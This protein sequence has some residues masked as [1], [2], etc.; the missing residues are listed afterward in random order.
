M[1]SISGRALGRTR[2]PPHLRVDQIPILAR[3]AGL[4]QTLSAK[5]PYHEALPMNKVFA[6]LDKESL[7][8]DCIAVLKDRCEHNSAVISNPMP[9]VQAA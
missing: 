7:D 6:I 5:R 3:I 1:H 2:R 4:A 8:R 9:L